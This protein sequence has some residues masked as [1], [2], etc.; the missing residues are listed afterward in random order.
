VSTCAPGTVGCVEKYVVTKP[1]GDGTAYDLTLNNGAWNTQARIYNG[2]AGAGTLIKTITTDFDFTNACPLVGCTGNAY[3]RPTR[4]TITDPVP[5][6]SIN[7]K[8]E[9]SYDS[10]YYGNVNAKKEWLYY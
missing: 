7:K 10:I 5:S 1:S 3:V 2:A 9:Y 6:R 8:T 4:V